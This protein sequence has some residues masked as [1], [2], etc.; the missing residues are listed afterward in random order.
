MIIQVPEIGSEGLPLRGCDPAAILDIA[1]GTIR[2]ASDVSYD[3][4]AGVSDGGIFVT[5]SLA[6]D[7]E[8]ECVRCCQSFVASVRV[9]EFAIQEDLH[10]RD[11]FD[12]TPHMREDILLVLPTHPQCGRD[13]DRQCGGFTAPQVGP[14]GEG[15]MD[16]RWDQ[17]DQLDLTARKTQNTDKDNGSSQT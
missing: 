17:L 15:G 7:I 9:P 6:V 2:V 4:F 12:L 1:D 13:G 3:L 16:D 10:G 5:G 14:A 8:F 11:T